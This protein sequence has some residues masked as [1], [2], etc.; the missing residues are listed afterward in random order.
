MNKLILFI[1]II[2]G[3]CFT[4]TGM[5][6]DKKDGAFGIWVEVI[7]MTD[8]PKTTNNAP[9]IYDNASAMLSLDYM[10]GFG[11]ELGIDY[12]SGKET[13]FEPTTLAREESEY[14]IQGYSA[15]YHFKSYKGSNFYLGYKEMEKFEI[16]D[17][18]L[19]RKKGE[20]DQA[21]ICSQEAS[22]FV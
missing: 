3:F 7:G 16:E 15:A 22:R 2:I 9:A 4:Q 1:V 5:L 17:D 14:Q 13:T 21:Q 11:L 10:F 20:N 6:A 12:G 18:E 19:M 8:A